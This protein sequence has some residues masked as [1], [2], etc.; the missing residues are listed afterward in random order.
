ME[1][2][3][4]KTEVSS[5][6]TFKGGSNR[7]GCSRL[8]LRGESNRG[9]PSKGTNEAGEASVEG[10]SKPCERLEETG[11]SEGD[12]SENSGGLGRTILTTGRGE[13]TSSGEPRRSVLTGGTVLLR[14][15]EEGGSKGHG[16]KWVEDGLSGS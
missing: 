16:S 8:K 12:G 10:E 5:K 3:K 11:A 6:S 7:Y 9:T 14:E 2:S 4:L 1:Q 15:T 13:D